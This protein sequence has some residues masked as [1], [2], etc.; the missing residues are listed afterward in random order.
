MTKEKFAEILKD[1][2]LGRQSFINHTW[3]KVE[4][5]YSFLASLGMSIKMMEKEIRE[6]AKNIIKKYGKIE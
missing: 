2:G 4:P 1:E 3:E 5:R 6:V